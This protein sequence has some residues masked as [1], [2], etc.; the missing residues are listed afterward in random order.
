MKKFFALF[1]GILFLLLG[2]IGLILPILPGWVFFFIG[3]S[4]IAP[5]F[6]HRLKQ[7]FLRRFVK[8]EIVYCE[9]W[10]SPAVRAG[11]TT[12][13]FPLVLKKTDDLLDPVNQAALR[14]SLP[15]SSKYVFLNQV[16][17][18]T[19]SALEKK[20]DFLQERF[21]HLTQTD[22]AVTC[23]PGLV[24]VV[25]TAD[26]LPVF[27]CAGGWVGLAHAGWRGTRE[28]I[29]PKT[30]KLLLEKS[31]CGP[32]DIHVMLGPCIGK[33]NY[34]VG[35]EFEG[36]FPASS[37]FRKNGKL[38]LDLAGENKRQLQEA[39]VLRRNIFDTGICTVEENEDFYSFR[40]ERDS[41]GRTI[42]FITKL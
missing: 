21:Y 5:D 19:I 28:K 27:F 26:C 31:A 14:A 20:E 1:A 23:L 17:G 34:E 25:L 9:H 10:R 32:E 16:H 42:S 35:G 41:A 36:Y 30:F 3:L 29:A 39:G 38:H 12:R 8:K 2:V 33:R 15:I 13:R 18:A 40:K 22:A 7:R 37:L 4:F 24:L 6:A 11:F